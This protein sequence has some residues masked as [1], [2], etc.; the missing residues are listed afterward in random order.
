[1]KMQDPSLPGQWHSKNLSNF[2]HPKDPIHQGTESQDSFAKDCWSASSLFSL[3]VSDNK[4]RLLTQ[5][6][7]VR[8]P[9]LYCPPAP[10]LTEKY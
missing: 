8:S 5:S 3:L 2:K 10:R 1:M 9:Q 7:H 4:Y 6:V